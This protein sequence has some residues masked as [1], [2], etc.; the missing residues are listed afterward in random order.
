VQAALWT[1]AFPASH[2]N[3]FASIS[4]DKAYLFESF[5]RISYTWKQLIFMYFFTGMTMTYDTDIKHG[6][7]AT[8][9][10]YTYGGYSGS[11]TVHNK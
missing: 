2:A 7:I 3:F 11:Q 9:S 5:M 6:H 8:D 1:V 10:G 4:K